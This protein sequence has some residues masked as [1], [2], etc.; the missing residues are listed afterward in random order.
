MFRILLPVDL[1]ASS[2]NA[3]D[4]AMHVAAAAPEA[5]LLLLH[6]FS[7]YLLE[8]E[9]E[10][11]FSDT[12]RSPLSPGSEEVTDRVLHRNQTD[13]HAG[14]DELYEELQAKANAHGQHVHLKRAFING[15]PEDVIPEEIKRF[16]PDLL[17]MGT[18]GEDNFVRSFFGT[19]T[20]KMIDDAKVPLLTVPESYQGRSL[21]RILYATDFDKTD[22]QALASLQL[23]LRAFNPIIVCAHIGTDSSEEKDT[24]KLAQLEDRL[25]QELP[26]HALQFA[27]L[28]GDDVAEALQ[29][30]VA[31]EKVELIAVNNHQR[32]LLSSIFQPSLSKKLVLEMQVPMLIFHSP[33][34]A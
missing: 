9:L 31:R 25:N 14:L 30:F 34:K 26:N 15:M 11:P 16:K 29:E 33:G 18:K 3:C 8:P 32:S 4:Y 22:A 24:R 19:V 13:E 1:T 21:R 20:T 12:G 6:C 10:N 27:L 2:S 28:Q 23:L 5:E 7:D 17:V